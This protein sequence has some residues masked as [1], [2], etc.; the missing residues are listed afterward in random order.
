[1]NSQAERAAPIVRL[2]FSQSPV[3]DQARVNAGAARHLAHNLAPKVFAFVGGETGSDVFQGRLCGRGRSVLRSFFHSSSAEPRGIAR[4]S[5]AQRSCGSRSRASG[6]FAGH[7]KGVDASVPIVAK[8]SPWQSEN[9]TLGAAL[10]SVAVLGATLLS[11]SVAKTLRKKLR[12][13]KRRRHRRRQ[14]SGFPLKPW[15]WGESGRSK[16]LS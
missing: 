12:Q 15:P 10:L 5:A 1:M 9:E 8:G 16:R 6:F 11:Q 7:K 13:L 4:L 3:T 14:L 2:L